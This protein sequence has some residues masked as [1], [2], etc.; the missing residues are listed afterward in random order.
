M[1]PPNDEFMNMEDNTMKKKF[2]FCLI[3]IKNHTHL[4]IKLLMEIRS[5]EWA[6][7]N[8]INIIMWIPTV[9]ALK[10]KFEAYKNK[11]SEVTKKNIPLGE[12]VSLV[13]DMFVADTM[14]EA[15]EKAGEHMV[16]YM[17]WVCHWRGLGNH[18]DPGE[19]L[20]ETKGKLDLLNY[21]FLHKRNMFLEPL[22]SDR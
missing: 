19:E 15:K 9:K 17:R 11:R 6:A 7:E 21:E 1:S 10:A 12:G 5:I 3:H 4:F 18:M 8:N 13:R 14:E 16:N 22:S 2:V 20:P